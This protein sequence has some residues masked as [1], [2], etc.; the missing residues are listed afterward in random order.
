M[1]V[2]AECA[3]SGD[4]A[5]EESIQDP[6]PSSTGTGGS[7]GG[8]SGPSPTRPTH[9]RSEPKVS[10]I[11]LGGQHYR[12]RQYCSVACLNSLQGQTSTVNRQPFE[13]Y[14]CGVDLRSPKAKA[15]HDA[16][17][18]RMRRQR[19]HGRPGGPAG[20]HPAPARPL[21]PRRRRHPTGVRGTAHPPEGSEPDKLLEEVLSTGGPS[22][23]WEASIRFV[24]R[25]ARAR[26]SAV[27]AL[28]AMES[29]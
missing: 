4:E 16:E 2:D 7:L 24:A 20:Q 29:G 10:S 5:M 27:D 28:P 25:V 15:K 18:R 17:R 19:R 22:G 14:V 6:P 21:L 8:P 13:C 26:R 23:R 1:P 12:G 9:R 11:D 3:I